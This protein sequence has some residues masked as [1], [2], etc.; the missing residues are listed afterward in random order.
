MDQFIYQFQFFVEPPTK[1]PPIPRNKEESSIP[2]EVLAASARGLWA[3]QMRKATPDFPT[4]LP[5]LYLSGHPNQT[6]GGNVGSTPPNPVN[7]DS[8]EYLRDD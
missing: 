5:K 6:G 1:T 3:Q 8:L 4:L 7:V 2:L